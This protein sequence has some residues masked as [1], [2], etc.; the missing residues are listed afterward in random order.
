M[1]R[2]VYFSFDYR[3][4]FKVN[5]IRAVPNIVSVAPAGFSSASVWEEAKEKGGRV[6]KSIIDTAL[7][8][9]SVTVVCVAAG[10]AED[11]HINYAIEQSL[12]RKNGLV[13]VRIHE[14]RDEDG[15]MGE[16]GIVPEQIEANGFKSYKYVNGERLAKRIEEAAE[17]AGR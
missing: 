11:E 15:K 12:A 7:D 6:V 1:K 3:D 9:T 2:R 14:L 8:D 13:A 4:L 5:Q 10:V 16:P 17:I